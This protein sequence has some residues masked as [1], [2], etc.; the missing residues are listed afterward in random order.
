MERPATA[1]PTACRNTRC[2]R[3]GVTAVKWFL[4]R[5][6]LIFALLAAAC[7]GPDSSTVP[8]THLNKINHIIIVML[9]NHSFDNY[10]GS[11]AYVPGSPYH[12]SSEAAR[13][14]IIVVSTG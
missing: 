12:T 11:L 9:E 3:E 1:W 4:T 2:S 5:A 7:S 14:T 10:F 13:Q 8:A 6:Q